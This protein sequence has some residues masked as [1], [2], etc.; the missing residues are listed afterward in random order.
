MFWIALAGPLSNLCLSILGVLLLVLLYTLAEA[1]SVTSIHILVLTTEVFIY[2]NLLL[3][4]FNL[5]P[6]HPLDGG[7]VLARFLPYRWNIFMEQNQHYFS[8]ALI[9]LFLLGGFHYLALPVG[10]AS[11]SLIGVAKGLSM[12]L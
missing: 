5:L 1:F 11:T 6:L 3:C 2:L 7:K 12:I 9:A 8:F 10:W 4:C